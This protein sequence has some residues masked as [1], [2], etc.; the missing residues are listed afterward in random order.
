VV[1]VAAAPAAGAP[2]FSTRLSARG[3]FLVNAAFVVGLL[4]LS[5][6]PLL[7]SRPVV[8][9]SIVGAAVVLLAWSLLLFGV[10]RRG[11]TVSFEIALRPQHYLQ[12][13]LQGSL[14]LTGGTGA[15]CTTRRR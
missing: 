15:R 3:A 12:A 14:I 7:E 4:V 5:Q 1:T 13:C 9:A 6:L 10:L 2:T 11:Q 8:R